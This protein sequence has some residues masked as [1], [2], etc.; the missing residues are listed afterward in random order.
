LKSEQNDFVVELMK[1]NIN[2]MNPLLNLLVSIIFILVLA[3]L[4]SYYYYRFDLTTEKRYT[5]SEISR[6]SLHNLKDTVHIRVY[7]DGDLNIPF[8]KMRQSIMEILDEFKVY[9]KDN[10]DYIF[11]NP[12]DNKDPKMNSKIISELYEK[13]LKPTNIHARDKEGGSSEKMIFPGALLSY[14]DVE[15]PVNLLKNNPGLG[16]EENIN[17]SIQALEFEFIRVISS[18][19]P[20]TTER[21]AFIEGHGELDEYHVRDVTNDLG[22]YFQVDRGKIDG[23]P[24]ILDRYKAVIIAKPTGNFSE[25]DKFVLDQYL[26]NGGK[27]L[28]FLDMVDASMD[29]ISEGGSMIAL[30]NQH[31]LD[32]VLFRYGV[33]VNPVLVQDV[34]CNMI[35]V[36]VAFAGTPAD[37]R[38]APWLYS[39]LLSSPN[40]HP[41]TRN[42]NMI[43]TEFT[44]NIDTI[45]TRKAIKRTVL[46]RSSELSRHINPPAMISLD[47]VRIPLRQELFTSKYQPIAVLL[48]GKF[49]TAFKNRGISELF[50][51]TTLKIIGSSKQTGMLVVAD[52]DII[53]NDIRLTPQGMLISP[54]G[55]DRYTQQTFGNKEFILNAIHYL[56]GHAALIDL[57]SRELTLRL[58]DKS[59]ITTERLK[60]ILINTVGPPLLIILTGFVFTWLRKKRY[61]GQ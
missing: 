34:Q 4:L 11:I 26:M 7:L 35:P 40:T 43:R 12:F 47:E 55:F 52:G 29:S 2:N 5:L 17:N 59:K 24:G 53:R 3:Y 54:L 50:P 49:E 36:N 57:R 45:G 23:R 46:L 19:S 33:R 10:L 51:D 37:F 8:R 14:R 61:S 25:Q 41:I 21:I 1:T 13:G 28:W 20:D 27:I 38:P 9:A 39:P 15:V 60:W 6:T 31:N 48:E 56:T 30:I 44:G 22:W 58:L 42:L 16:P 32:D 18:L